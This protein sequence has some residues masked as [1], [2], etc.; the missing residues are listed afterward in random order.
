MLVLLISI[1]LNATAEFASI[2]KLCLVFVRGVNGDA[3]SR[4]N[5]LV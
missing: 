3:H 1:F 5:Q 2:K 4:S